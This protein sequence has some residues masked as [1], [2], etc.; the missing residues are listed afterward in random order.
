MKQFAQT[1]FDE[2]VK[3]PRNLSSHK[4][5]QKKLNTLFD[6]KVVLL[7][8]FTFIQRSYKIWSANLLGITVFHLPVGKILD[9]D[10]EN[11]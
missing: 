10:I 3:L 8:M 9:Q 1:K 5:F 2:S 11:L 4:L 7:S 6:K